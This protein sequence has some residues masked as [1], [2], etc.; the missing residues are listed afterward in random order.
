MPRGGGRTG[1]LAGG[2]VHFD[3]ESLGDTVSQE[4]R[5]PLVLE[6]SQYGMPLVLGEEVD[7][8]VLRRCD[9]A[10]QCLQLQQVFRILVENGEEGVWNAGVKQASA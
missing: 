5:K 4:L 8:R 6:S 2:W 10:R 3:A 1:T 9:C 7:D